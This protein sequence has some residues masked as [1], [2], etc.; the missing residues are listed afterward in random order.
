MTSL[1]QEQLVLEEIPVK[2]Y[3]KVVRARESKSGLDAVIAI[4]DLRLCS[5]ALGGTRIHAYDSF[6]AGLT[7]A[8]RLARGMTFKSAASQCGF[9]GGKSVIILDPKKGKTEALLTAFA[10]AV[11]RLKGVY[12]CAEDAGCTP[13]D[14]MVIA[15]HTPYIVGFPNEKSS[16]NPS[17]FTSWG[18]FRGIQ[19]VMHQL[20]G[21]DSVKGRTVAIQGLGSVGA[22]LAEL[23]FWH[24]AKLIITDI[25]MD[26]AEGVAK[27]FDAKLVAPDAI[28]DQP[29]DVFAPCAMGGIINPQSI[30]R[31]RCRAIAGAANNQLLTESDAEELRR[32]GILYAPDF[33]INSGGL[34]NVTQEVTPEGYNPSAALARVEQIYDQL[35]LIFEI[36]RQNGISTQKAVMQLIQY[37]LQHGIG[38]RVDP[39]YL[40]HAGISY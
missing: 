27:A 1:L 26:R 35:K 29:C 22:R 12:I 7:D 38:K 18:I 19:A 23:L 8:L 6:E 33:V 36:A 15:E 16:G 28:F 11:N 40:H 21:S 3:H 24:G 32:V 4:H 13:S 31:L 34:I 17:P 10:E 39:I 37:R 30:E 9:G 14:L 20:F 5:T 2:G 25:H